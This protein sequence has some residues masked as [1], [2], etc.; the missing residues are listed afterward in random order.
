MFLLINTHLFY[1]PRTT[2]CWW[3]WKMWSRGKWLLLLNIPAHCL[4]T[5]NRGTASMNWVKYIVYSKISIFS[6]V[7][8]VVNGRSKKNTTNSGWYQQ[9]IYYRSVPAKI[10]LNRTMK[11]WCVALLQAVQWTQN[12]LYCEIIWKTQAA[13]TYTQHSTMEMCSYSIWQQLSVKSVIYYCELSKK[14]VVICVTHA[15]II[16]QLYSSHFFPYSPSYLFIP[17]A[18]GL[19]RRYMG[20]SLRGRLWA[21]AHTYTYNSLMLVF[22]TH[23]LFCLCHQDVVKGTPYHASSCS[24]NSSENPYAT[25]KDPPLLTAKNTEC[26]YM[27]MKSPA[28]R[29]SP[30]AE[31]NNS[32]PTNNRNVYE[33]GQQHSY[34]SD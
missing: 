17:G 14:F 6:F 10:N 15:T 12:N 3:T 25:I 34:I 4:Q 19:D 32:S 2:R 30:Y 33:V 26:G 9:G 22:S 16:K 7:F 27:E 29:D 8:V 28:R 21:C 31:I 24:L 23:W 13:S 5:G 1:R 11:C 18:Y 20:K